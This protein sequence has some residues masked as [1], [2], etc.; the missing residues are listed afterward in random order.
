MKEQFIPTQTIEASDVLYSTDG[1]ELGIDTFNPEGAETVVDNWGGKKSEA[2][3]LAEIGWDD[4]L[5]VDQQSGN[6]TE[7]YDFGGKSISGS[8]TVP[9]GQYTAKEL[10]QY[11]GFTVPNGN[12]Q[13]SGRNIRPHS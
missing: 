7:S 12:Y 13:V 2:E 8:R 3:Q 11:Y 6:S 5:I 10:K 1:S 9:D 4:N